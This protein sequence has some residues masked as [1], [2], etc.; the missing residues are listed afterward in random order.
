MDLD[1]LMITVFCQFD[2][3]LNIS[4]NEMRLRQFHPHSVLCDSEVVSEVISA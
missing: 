2:D 4:L 1:L 3:A